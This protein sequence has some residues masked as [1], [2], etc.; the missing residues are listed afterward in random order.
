[1][2]VNG[3]EVGVT[4]LRE[5][6]PVEPGPVTVSGRR[7]GYLDASE[8]GAVTE[9]A[10]LSVALELDIDPNAHPSDLGEL[11]LRAPSV[12]RTLLV[13]GREVDTSSRIELPV[14]EHALQLRVEERVPIRDSIVIEEEEPTVFAPSFTWTDEA[15]R[16]RVDRAD[17]TRFLGWIVGAAGLVTTGVGAAVLI[18]NETLIAEQNDLWKTLN[19]PGGCY[20]EGTVCETANPVE[21]A[22]LE[23]LGGNPERKARHPIRYGAMAALGVGVI[24]MGFGIGLLI[25]A[26]SEEDIDAAAN[27]FSAT[28][29]V[30]PTSAELVG[31]F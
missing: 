25:A 17:T 26:P 22:R 23:E 21:T 4:P 18:W 30:T 14:G 28:L 15:R 31:T 19:S 16:T 10:E 20:F 27:D 8:S 24:A 12:E 1:M 6:V 9:D 5:T 13:D 29:R 11:D 7:R 3:R 2:L